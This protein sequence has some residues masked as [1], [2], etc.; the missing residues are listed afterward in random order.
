M[1]IPVVGKHATKCG[2]SQGIGVAAA[3]VMSHR[4]AANTLVMRWLWA[5]LQIPVM[6]VTR[7]LFLPARRLL[8]LMV[9][10]CLLMA[11]VLRLLNVSAETPE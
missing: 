5:D 3:Q 1:V 10:I 7:S 11:G 4:G 9:S 8:I 2:S 6:L